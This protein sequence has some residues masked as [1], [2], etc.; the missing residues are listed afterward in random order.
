MRRLHIITLVLLSIMIF[1]G[2]LGSGEGITQALSPET[3]KHY[4]VQ[5]KEL[6]DPTEVEDQGCLRKHNGK[7]PVRGDDQSWVDT[8]NRDS[9]DGLGCPCKRVKKNHR[10]V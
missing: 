5:P 6:P 7:R 8:V 10:E 3:D 4:L 9:P 2:L 1:Q